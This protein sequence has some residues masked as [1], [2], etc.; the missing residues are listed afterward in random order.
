MKFTSSTEMPV[1]QKAH[2]LVLYIYKLTATF[3]KDEV[4]ELNSQI[5]RVSLSVS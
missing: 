5:R 3:P 1:W 2:R 4:Y